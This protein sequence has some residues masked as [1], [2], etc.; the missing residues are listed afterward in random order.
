MPRIRPL[1]FVNVLLLMVPFAAHAQTSGPVIQANSCQETDVNAVINGPTHVAANGDTI[2]IPTGTCTWNSTISISGKGF[3]I[4]GA[5]TP[6]TLP[7]QVGAAPSNTTLIVN[8]YGGGQS[9]GLPLFV[10][11]NIP[12]GKTMRISMLNIQPVAGAGATTLVGGLSFVGTCTVSGCP[13]IRV[14]NIT[15]PS[16]WDGPLRGGLI[17]AD[18]VFG[19]LDHNTA[20]GVSLGP[21]LVQLAHSAWQGI[22]GYGDNSFASADTFGTSQALYIENNL[23][24]L[25]RGTE[26]DVNAMG[27]GIGGNRAVCRYNTF[28]PQAGT[29]VCSSHGTSWLGRFRGQRQ[30]EVYRNT[31]SCPACDAG[32][33]VNSG[34]ELV[35]ENSWTGSWNELV[36]LDVPRDWHS[37]A[38][39]N[40]CD[41]A[42]PYDTNDGTTYASGTVGTGGTTT[43]SD[44]SKNW[45]INQWA[46]SVVTNGTPY[47]VHDVTQN[48]GAAILSN[49]ATQYSFTGTLA[50]FKWNAGD[51]YQIRRAT[52]CID[53]PGRS[54]G[55]LYSGATPSPT[56]A[57]QTLDPIYEW[58]DTHSG[59]GGTPITSRDVRLIANRDFYSENANQG[60][61]TSNSS[62]FTGNPDTGPGVGHGTL[63]NRPTTCT[64]GVAYWATD[65]GS[66]NQSG[67]GEQGELFTCTAT[68]NWTLKYEPYT[69]PSPLITGGTSGTSTAPPTNL[70]A[71]VQ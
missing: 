40:Y 62:P 25:A 7:S 1:L 37:I 32:T 3:T 11:S 58:G 21:P 39:W 42:Q 38:P 27:G 57:N 61:Q 15:F 17:L 19:V 34:T 4:V 10:V 26:N 64:T 49:T 29:G 44:G 70:T 55:T 47:S 24:S 43:F 5:G 52:A 59:G 71:T 63:A 33:G 31:I 54:G 36:T 13:N 9:W 14:D 51:S 16:S 12:Y 45:A 66:W 8:T 41:G 28:N 6:N 67:S 30:V 56:A 22:G 53:Q 60:A 2:Q 23:L 20:S 35:F 69:Y 50:Y 46:G 65:Q 48:V 18:G 68:N